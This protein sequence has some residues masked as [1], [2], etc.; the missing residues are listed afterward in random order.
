MRVVIL[1]AGPAGTACGIQLAKA[2]ID[3][4]ILDKNTFP[5]HAPGETLHP[6]IEPL[7][8]QLGVWH[9]V[10]QAG[11]IRHK[12]ITSQFNQESL[13]AA[14][15]EE[16]NWQ[17]FQFPRAQFDQLMLQQA[18]SCG[19]EFIDAVKV[20]EVK[21]NA[22]N[23]QLQQLS[24]TKTQDGT[25]QLI[26][27]DY[28]IDA[29]GKRAFLAEK[30]AI[31]WRTF[32][33]KRT[34]LYGYVESVP[35][36]DLSNPKMIWDK[37][38]WTW[39]AKTRANEIAWARLDLREKI[40][41]NRNWRPEAI[42]HLSAL[43]PRKAENVTWRIAEQVV[44]GNC[45]LVGDAAFVLDP[46]SS[47]GVLK[48]IMSGM[49]VAHLLCSL[50]KAPL[51]QIQNAYS[52]WVNEWFDKDVERLTDLYAEAMEKVNLDNASLGA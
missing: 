29:S 33:E 44:K 43:R 6:G 18:I 14:Y 2:G 46:A 34:A 51:K 16:E 22:E 25:K 12:G 13:F 48:A 21:V 39:L 50:D 19:C 41:R 10:E 52:D 15:N 23:G 35:E 7:L 42:R 37:E 24:I 32:S 49:M 38:G 9:K 1:G 28:F 45:F 27:A 20:D 40:K 31:K 11:F 17:G 8:K 26:N 47:H 5:R 30:L 3:V 36:F 4:V